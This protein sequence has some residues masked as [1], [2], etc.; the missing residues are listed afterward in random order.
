MKTPSQN[1]LSNS[2]SL[3][4]P[5]GE[6]TVTYFLW[7]SI[8]HYPISA[9]TMSYLNTNLKKGI[10]NPVFHHFNIPN[11][12]PCQADSTPLP[13]KTHGIQLKGSSFSKTVSFSLNFLRRSVR[14]CFHLKK[15]CNV[16]KRPGFSRDTATFHPP[17]CPKVC[18]LWKMWAN[19]RHHY[20][21]FSSPLFKGIRRSLFFT[22]FSRGLL[23]IWK[24]TR[25]YFWKW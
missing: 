20:L 1:T 2:T 11:I 17:C 8:R 25:E 9:E 4:C 13:K 24:T 14:T 10:R 23:I 16:K 12:S 7:P 6:F 21:T 5:C 19:L 18:L 3:L 22:N 15:P